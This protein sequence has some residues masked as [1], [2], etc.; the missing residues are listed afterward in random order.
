MAFRF[1][2]HLR[3]APGIRLNFGKRGVSLSAGVRG[4]TVTA[5]QRGVHGNVGLPGSGLSY[6][7]RLDKTPRQ[8]QRAQEEEARQYRHQH[9]QE[10]QDGA[11]EMARVR[12]ILNDKGQL[13]I[14][15]V[16]HQEI[17]GNV[18]RRLLQDYREDIQEWLEIEC[19][20][21]NGDMDLLQN[22]H[23]DTLAPDAPAPSYE[24]LPFTEPSPQKPRFEAI[25]SRPTPPP[26]FEIRWWE[27]LWPGRAASKTRTWEEAHHQ[28]QQADQQWQVDQEQ[29]RLK[30]EA[31]ETEYQKQMQGW[32]ERKDKH[33]KGQAEEDAAFAQRL[34][35]ETKL[36]G[37]VLEAE[38]SAL[39]WPRE[40]LIDFEVGEQGRHL[41]IDVDLPGMDQFPDKKARLGAR[42][43]RLVITSKS[44]TQLRQEYAHHLHAVLLRVLGT[45]FASLP[46][47]QTITLSGYT[48]RM[49]SATGHEEDDYLISVRVERI[50]FA[51]I[52]FNNLDAVDPIQALEA[53]EL[54]RD[55]SKSG[56]FKTIAPL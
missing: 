47:I 14:E 22:L 31:V 29:H 45:A 34:L 44:Q 53:F 27:R 3:I 54:V 1:R 15:D 23:L 16:N 9:Q 41:A 46:S 17:T 19:E 56:I 42:E 50:A 43:L 33:L 21:I 39:D 12:L 38:L 37:E 24:I 55:M 36:M 25:P 49:D 8:R 10:L 11:S 35:T 2:Q 28:W 26:A 40:T 6:R 13:R 18:R 52:N 51:A 7:T 5:G 4:A 30:Q 20:R 32:R 48:Q